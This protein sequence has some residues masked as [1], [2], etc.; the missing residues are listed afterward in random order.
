MPRPYMPYTTP[1]RRSSHLAALAGFLLLA[2][3][4]TWPLVLHPGTRYPAA[5]GEAAQDLWQNIWNLWWAG[6]ALRRGTNP[7]FTDLLFAPNGAS[8][9]FHP[10]NL[11][12]GVLSFPLQFA[13]LPWAYNIAVLVAQMLAGYAVYHLARNTGCGA[14]AATTGCVAYMAGAWFFAHL[15]LGHLEQLQIHWLPLFALALAA[16]Q[17]K[18]TPRRVL[19]AALVAIA[20]TFT[21]LYI[22]LFAAL[23]STIWFAAALVQGA[24]RAALLGTLAVAAIALLVVGPLLFWPMWQ[25]TRQTDYMLRTLAD[26]A[27]GSIAPADV[28]L[29]PATHP[30]RALLAL[31]APQSTT[32]FLGFVPLALAFAAVIHRF[33]PN[34]TVALPAPGPG[35][36]P[37]VRAERSNRNAALPSPVAG[38]GPGGRA[39]GQGGARWMLLA[40]IAFLLALGP[41]YPFY[42]ALA[43]LPPLQIARYAGHFAL[44]LLLATSVLAAIGVQWLLQRT[45]LPLWSAWL[46]PLLVLAELHPRGVP[47]QEPIF[48]P[49]YA[50]IAQDPAPTSLLELPINRANNVWVDMAAQTVHQHPILYGGLA[51]PVP[52]VPFERMALFQD[53]ER[54]TRATDIVVQPPAQR[55]AALQYFRLSR[56]AYHR[57]DE[58]G[59]VVVPDAVALSN[60]AGVPVRQLYNDAKLVG[61]ALDLPAGTAALPPFAAL[62]GGWYDRET[63]GQGEPL[64]WLRGARGELLLYRPGGATTMTLDV[65]AFATAREVV[66][67]LDRQEIARFTAQPWPTTVHVALPSLG[68]DQ[69]LALVPQGAG[70][71]PRAAGIGDD[72]RPLTIAV[73]R[74]LI[75]ET[76]Q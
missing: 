22:A 44:P 57:S 41:E 30:I 65:L 9:L 12:T 64:R 63:G 39:G 25:E 50:Q 40:L 73:T 10:L 14:A 71:T 54:P 53:L 6:E 21:S 28:V 35:A 70:T 18:P 19:L 17:R 74:V 52:R 31:P 38:G 37:G 29:P 60:A 55:I 48:N 36:G 67:L 1:M 45:R 7:L 51:R 20:I 5:G 58:N 76:S 2:L 49:W 24:R 32:A 61:F 4:L 43:V 26:A 11:T 27:T 15:R 75:E 34:R 68:G 13:G 59:P 16:A 69:T 62:G 23:L 72:S 47:L 3:I 66:V 33:V 42:R 8:L 46:L 56:I